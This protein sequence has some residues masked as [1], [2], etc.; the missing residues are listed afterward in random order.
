MWLCIC[1]EAFSGF[2]AE[3]VSKYNEKRIISVS[4]EYGIELS[5]VRGA[6]DNSTR[7]LEVLFACPISCI[8]FL[9]LLA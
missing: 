1:R 2:D 6:V 9:V 5:L 8:P 7:I 4:A 3:A